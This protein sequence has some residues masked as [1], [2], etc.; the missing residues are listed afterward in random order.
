MLPVSCLYFFILVWAVCIILPHSPCSAEYYFH[1]KEFTWCLFSFCLQLVF[2]TRFMKF[3][4]EFFS[5]FSWIKMLWYRLLYCMCY[6]KCSVSFYAVQ[7]PK[8]NIISR[9]SIEAKWTFALL[10][11]PCRNAVGINHYSNVFFLYMGD[12][13]YCLKFL[14]PE[15]TCK[16][17]H[18]LFFL[19]VTR[20]LLLEL[21]LLW[22]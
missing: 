17:K 12:I 2:N 22:R 15:Y 13:F 10:C 7:S 21:C 14:S 3:L 6:Q 1:H 20:P 11:V 19:A 8:G 4:T 16:W 5:Y 9:E 18:H